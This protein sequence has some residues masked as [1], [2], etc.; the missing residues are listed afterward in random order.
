MKLGYLA[1][2]LFYYFIIGTLV[3]VIPT[4][5]S[6]G[7][8]SSTLNDDFNLTEVQGSIEEESWWGQFINIL[9]TLARFFGL[10]LFG[11]GLP[12]STPTLIVFVFAGWQTMVTILT[13]TMI[14]NGIRGH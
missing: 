1:L 11:I 7:A 2:I 13:A 9:G 12:S 8:T 10:L 5:I 14:I 3:A 6:D 4:S